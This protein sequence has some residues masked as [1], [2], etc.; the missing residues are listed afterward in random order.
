MLGP[1][2][3]KDANTY[4]ENAI[5][6]TDNLR[7]VLS[8]FAFELKCELNWLTPVTHKMVTDIDVETNG[9]QDHLISI[10]KMVL[11]D[12]DKTAKVDELPK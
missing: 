7:S 11:A 1:I 5:V 9:W 2:F 12:I 8:R 4:L 10:V 3:R 6:L